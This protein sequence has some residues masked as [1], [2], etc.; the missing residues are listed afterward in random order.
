L[1]YKLI[2]V[3]GALAAAAY[4]MSRRKRSPSLSLREL[5]DR[6]SDGADRI[7]RTETE[8]GELTF[9]SGRL[10]FAYVP[11]G[12]SVSVKSEFYFQNAQG[13]WSLKTHEERLSRRVLTREAMDELQAH[14]TVTFEIEPPAA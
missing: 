4:L 7:I 5:A 8:R 6:Y 12:P 3:G 13:E 11:E 14:R 9:I 2:A 1:L 10:T